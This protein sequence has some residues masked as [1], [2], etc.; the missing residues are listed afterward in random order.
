MKHHLVPE[1]RNYETV[2]TF[3]PSVCFKLRSL[4]LSHVVLVKRPGEISQIEIF[5]LKKSHTTFLY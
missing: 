2:L 5:S 3:Y 4:I 1:Q